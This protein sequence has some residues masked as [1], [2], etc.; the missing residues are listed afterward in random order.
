[1]ELWVRVVLIII[2]LI[3]ASISY[4]TLLSEHKKQKKIVEQSNTVERD[5]SIIVNRNKIRNIGTNIDTIVGYLIS[6]DIKT[7][8]R[9]TDED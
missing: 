6:N 4:Y 3:I 2:T 8:Y 9:Y 1:M 7:E 5:I